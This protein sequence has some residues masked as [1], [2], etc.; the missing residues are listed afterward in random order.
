MKRIFYFLILLM[1]IYIIYGLYLS[2]N[3]I[4]IVEKR[5]D[6][7]EIKTFYDFSGITHVQSHRS[8]GGGSISDIIT[9]AQESSLNFIYI[10]DLNFFK[11]EPSSF[12][13]YNDNLL[14]FRG[15]EYSYLSSR[16]LNYHSQ[17]KY[18]FKDFG[19]AQIIIGEQ[20]Q[21]KD[22]ETDYGLFVLSHPFHRKY[23]WYGKYP[24][25]LDGI[26]VLN[27]KTV[28]D[29]VWR[30][31]KLSF[32]YAFL[33]YPF[34]PKMMLV[35]ILE[36]PVK[37]IKLWDELSQRRK[38]IGLSGADANSKIRV[39]KDLFFKFPSYAF[40]FNISKNHV[41]L[42]SE[43]TGDAKTDAEK[44]Q[45]ALTEG[46]FYFSLDLLGD[47]TGFQAYIM[48]SK[49]QLFSIGEEILFQD[50]EKY[51][52]IVKLPQT[53]KVPFEIKVYKDGKLFHKTNQEYLN[54]SLL[55][56][57]VYRVTVDV[58]VGLPFPSASKRITWVYTNPFY[59]K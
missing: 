19:S 58:K 13:G 32:L 12:E 43:L 21:K 55:Q 10:T 38:T 11:Q 49:K 36:N 1:L 22:K 16:I 14:V 9:A 40:V 29:N 30:K 23:E 34:N 28:F 42:K 48:N 8:S 20:I 24:L 52:I 6:Q 39:S 50:N 59:I 37:N 46:S 41:L 3:D 54:L 31:S 25:G 35:R 57:G 53:M 51:Q 2:L 15:G 44:I 7:E 45:K 4:R 33:F 26:E 5:I 56:P 18:K 17:K 47:P 27:L